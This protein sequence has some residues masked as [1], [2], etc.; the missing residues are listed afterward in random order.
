MVQLL[1]R[2]TYRFP[3]PPVILT[4]AA[5]GGKMEGDGPLGKWFDYI[6]EDARFGEESWEKAENRMQQLALKTA[7]QKAG[8]RKTDLNL[9]FAGDLLNQCTGSSYGLRGFMVPYLGIYGACSTMA[10]GLLMAA[11]YT[12]AGLAKAAGAVTSSH[13]C[14]AERQYRFPLEYGCQRP[15]T[16]QWTATSAGAVIIGEND[17][18]S[19]GKVT[20]VHACAGI[21]QDGSVRDANNMGAAMAPAAA[22]LLRRYF[23][24]SGTGPRDY[25][26]IF[27]GDLG[28]VGSELLCQLLERDHIQIS[29]RHEDFGLLLYDRKK[30]DVH[31][32]GS[33]C[34]CSAG[35]LNGHILPEMRAGRL[36]DVLFAATGA[37][38]SPTMVQQ[39]ETIPGI[40][41]L[42]HLRME[43]GGNNGCSSNC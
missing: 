14:T 41:H 12:G 19:A 8:L 42:V 23:R 31:A 17:G 28:A 35:V 18:N 27:T 34:G 32:G 36:H 11:V 22:C 37:L 20:I 6:D 13:F 3:Q 2:S 39:G 43:Q 15:P 33:G 40:A 29:D 26:R 4:S 1:G 5:V 24:E 7:L 21:I 10:E 30:Q 9:L 38:L 16:A 25:D